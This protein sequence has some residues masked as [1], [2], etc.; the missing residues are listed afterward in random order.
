MSKKDLPQ[1]KIKRF[2]MENIKRD[3]T[4]LI[5]GKRRTGKSVLIADIMKHMRDIP[6]GIVFSGTESVN[7]F[8]NR[9]IPDLYIHHE[10]KP[11]IVQ[12]IF[13]AQRKKVRRE[14]KHE[15]NNM[16]IIMDDVLSSAED[17]KNDQTIK[18]IFFNGRHYN[19]FYILAIQ[20][21]LGI[22]P[23]LRNGVDYTFIFKENILKSRKML[24]ES[25]CGAVP[26]KIFQQILDSTTENHECLVV[27]N[28][29]NSNKIEDIF[30]YYKAK[31]HDNFKVG[32]HS[33][34]RH[35]NKKY[36]KH[37]DSDSDED[38]RKPFDKKYDCEIIKY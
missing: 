11:A 24:H 18:E 19:I 38:D 7:P 5:I 26:F 32:S 29:S 15:N 33:F 25:F 22:T 27:D 28:S 9:F 14:G 16:F 31:Q 8:Y 10:Y 17:W 6:K 30:Y 1:I 37:Y 21:G 2:D 12:E 4:I 13:K 3:S 23:N 36:N 34:W 20:Y 35:F